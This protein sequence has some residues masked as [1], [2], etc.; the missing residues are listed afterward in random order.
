MDH[1]LLAWFRNEARAFLG[2]N[3]TQGDVFGVTLLVLLWLVFGALMAAFA[4]IAVWVLWDSTGWWGMLG[5]AGF[6]IIARTVWTIVN[7]LADDLRPHTDR[8]RGTE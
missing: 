1:P 7:M 3:P 6:V 8:T 2:R 5:L 4:A